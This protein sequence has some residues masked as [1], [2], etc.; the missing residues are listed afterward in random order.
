MSFPRF[1]PYDTIRNDVF[2]TTRV[3]VKII[4]LQTYTVRYVVQKGGYTGYHFSDHKVWT[5]AE[6]IEAGFIEI[7]W[8]GRCG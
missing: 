5:V 8:D 2:Y 7:E 6:L 3:R 4:C 1:E